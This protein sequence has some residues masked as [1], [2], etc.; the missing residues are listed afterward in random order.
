MCFYTELV[1]YNMAI[2]SHYT[3]LLTMLV[4]LNFTELKT[5]LR[6]SLPKSMFV[7]IVW[8]GLAQISIPS[9]Q[10]LSTP[11]TEQSPCLPPCVLFPQM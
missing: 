9:S 5:T 10:M 2:N 3:A 1:L 6:R 4:S 7:E 8:D 11:L